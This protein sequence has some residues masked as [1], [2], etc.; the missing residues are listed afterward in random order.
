MANK[1]RY[2]RCE[3]ALKFLADAL[4]A[5]PKSKQRQMYLEAALVAYYFG[6]LNVR[7][8]ARGDRRG[9][10]PGGNAETILKELH[11]LVRR[12]EKPTTAARILLRARGFTGNLKG[13]ADHL[14][15]LFTK[16]QRA[17]TNN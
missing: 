10:P 15:R 9:R 2:A 13:R 4:R 17:T 3:D 11:A 8:N 16:K 12:G 7:V 1:P 14:A 5:P 6:L